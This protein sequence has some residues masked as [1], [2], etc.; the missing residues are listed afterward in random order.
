MAILLRFTRISY[1]G[2]RI[3][4]NLERDVNLYVRAALKSADQAAMPPRVAK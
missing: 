2:D 4:G 1:T 3:S